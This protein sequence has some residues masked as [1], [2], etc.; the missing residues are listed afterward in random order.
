MNLIRIINLVRFF[1]LNIYVTWR[2]C[3]M[4]DSHHANTCVVVLRPFGDFITVC[5]NMG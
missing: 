5:Q 4:T 2:T 3:A 1:F